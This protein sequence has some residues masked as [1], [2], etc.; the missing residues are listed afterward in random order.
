MYILFALVHSK[1][2]IKK[3]CKYSL[4][5][6][7]RIRPEPIHLTDASIGLQIHKICIKKVYFLT[8]H[9]HQCCGFKCIEFGSGSRIWDQF[10]SGF[11][12]YEII[13]K[14][15]LTNQLSLPRQLRLKLNFVDS[16]WRNCNNNKICLISFIFLVITLK[17]EKYIHK[18]NI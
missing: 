3:C 18:I 15:N 10:G 17:Y 16:C 9:K 14:K 5:L 12:S 13:F 1:F 2:V 8:I 6:R 7:I 11:Q 4:W